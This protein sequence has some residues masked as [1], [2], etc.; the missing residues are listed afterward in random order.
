VGVYRSGSNGVERRLRWQEGRLLL[1]RSGYPQQV[2]HPLEGGGWQIAGT[3]SRLQRDGKSL[4]H[5]PDGDGEPERWVRVGDLPRE[6]PALA[7][8]DEQMEALAGDYAGPQFE[9]RVFKS[10]GQGLMAQAPG[11]PAV[12]LEAQSPTRLVVKALGA[13]LD[14]ELSSGKALRVTLLQGPLRVEMSRR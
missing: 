3:L 14:F 4:R 2:L 7:L 6:T 11:Q 12:P 5:W 10:P 1:Q 8:N 13:T 9:L